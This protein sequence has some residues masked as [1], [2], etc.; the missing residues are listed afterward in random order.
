M[1][2]GNGVGEGQGRMKWGLKEGVL[3]LCSEASVGLGNGVGA[4][5]VGRGVSLEARKAAPGN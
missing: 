2:S 3:R 1:T 4:E 5:D